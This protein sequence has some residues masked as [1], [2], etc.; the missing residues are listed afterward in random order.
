M[1]EEVKR[2]MNQSEEDYDTA[3]VSYDAKK[4]YAA[5]FWCQQAAEKALKAFLI[6]KTGNFPKVHDLTKL[7]RL[8]N[9]PEEIIQFC[10][11]IN[12]AY[13]A[14]RYP[15]VAEKYTPNDAELTLKYGLKVLMDKKK[16]F[17]LKQ[18]KAF[19][20]K[21]GIERMYLFGSRAKGK[22]RPESDVDLIIVSPRFRGKGILERSPPLYLKW[23]Y[24]YPVDF[25][26][27]TPAEFVRLKKQ[28]SIVSQALR[29]G[30]EVK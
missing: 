21:N 30:I 23:E 9:A 11:K 26:C 8:C 27:Y 7:A 17:L 12:P 5:S 18:L 25:L 1:K 3:K 15:D 24:E 10:A 20:L 13:V 4:Y 19:K 29:D 22:P 6:G 2:W 14:T 16:H 28:V